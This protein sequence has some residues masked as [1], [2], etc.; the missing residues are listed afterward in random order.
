MSGNEKKCDQCAFCRNMTKIVALLALGLALC[1]VLGVLSLKNY[2]TQKE[3][4]TKE[5]VREYI[6][7]A[8]EYQDLKAEKQESRINCKT[9]ANEAEIAKCKYYSENSYG[10]PAE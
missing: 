2:I 6:E 8:A 7:S 10:Y 9:P 5:Y 4:A 1:G 3:F